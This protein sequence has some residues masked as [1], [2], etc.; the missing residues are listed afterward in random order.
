M[1]NNTWI[2]CS[3]RLPNENQNV[4]ACFAHGT[5][6]ELSFCCNKFHGIYDYDEKVIVAWQPLPEPYKAE[7]AVKKH[8]IKILPEYFA[9]VR[10]GRKKF[11]IRKND[12]SYQVGDIVQLAEFEGQKFTGNVI[13]V[14]ISY[15]L[16]DCPQYG[17]DEGYCI[18]CWQ[19]EHTEKQG[20]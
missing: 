2:P 10:A 7:D 6:T 1:K 8:I 4:I 5:V 9:D 18:F 17:L 14:Q 20:G 11:E 12:R 19:S 13:E 15:I 16:R 3:E